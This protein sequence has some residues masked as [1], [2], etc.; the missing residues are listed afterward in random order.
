MK[1][2]RKVDWKVLLPTRFGVNLGETDIEQQKSNLQYIKDKAYL[3]R[4]L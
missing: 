4:P 3:V 2:D 1:E